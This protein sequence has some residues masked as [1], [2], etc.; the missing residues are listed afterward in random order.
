MLAIDRLSCAFSCQSTW[1]FAG[2]KMMAAAARMSGTSSPFESV[3][4]RGVIA[5]CSV[6]M[7]AISRE[8]AAARARAR[9]ALRACE[10]EA[11]YAGVRATLG[12]EVGATADR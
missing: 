4:Y 3:L 11:E 5:S 12:A 10:G 7:R 1:P 2:L 9:R 6:R 8:R